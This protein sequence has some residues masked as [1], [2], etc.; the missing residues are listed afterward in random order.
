M[1]LISLLSQESIKYNINIIII[2]ITEAIKK[3]ATIQV[4]FR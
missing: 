1:I 2:I 3:Y 4:D